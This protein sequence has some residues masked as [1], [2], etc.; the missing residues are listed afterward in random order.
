MAALSSLLV[1]ASVCTARPVPFW[2]YDLLTERADLFVISTPT[3]T[4]ETAQNMDLPGIRRGGLDDASRPV[5]GVGLQT[6]FDV[7]SVFKGD[8]SLKSIVLVHF[9]DAEPQRFS[10]NSPGWCRS[11]PSRR[12]D[13]FTF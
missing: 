13:T 6:T 12:G 4:K 2:P 1:M 5:P 11:I 7:L 9:R 3:N 8:K 10:A